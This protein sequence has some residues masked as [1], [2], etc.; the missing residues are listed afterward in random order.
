M[1][2]LYTEANDGFRVFSAEG[3]VVAAIRMVYAG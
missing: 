1:V 3:I 2:S